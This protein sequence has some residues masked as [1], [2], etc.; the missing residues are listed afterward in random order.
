MRS[1]SSRDPRDDASDCFAGRWVIAAHRA[2]ATSDAAKI[3]DRP[4][5]V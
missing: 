2:S 1:F 4:F 5:S 3:V